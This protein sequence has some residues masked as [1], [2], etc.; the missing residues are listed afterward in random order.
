MKITHAHIY[1][2]EIEGRRP[3]IVEIFTDAGISGLG[4]AAIAYGCG[5]TAAAGMIK[6]LLQEII[7]GRDP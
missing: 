1:L 6:D 3:I 4:E 2:V 5:A 7:L